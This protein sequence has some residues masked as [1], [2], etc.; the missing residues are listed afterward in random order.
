[1]IVNGII[2]IVI[3]Y[4][5][6]SI[7]SAYIVVRLTKGKDIREL[8]SGTVGSYNTYR[9]AGAKAGIAVAIADIGKGVATIA[10]AHYL[11]D[12]RMPFILAAGFA[13]IVGH[14]WMPLL[15]FRGGMGM[16]T[17]IGVMVTLLA[18]QQYWHQLFIFIGVIIV[19]LLITRNIALS[20]ATALLALPIILWVG[21]KSVPFTI[22]AAVIFLI[23]GL[24]F[25]PTA[26]AA[27]AKKKNKRS[28]FFSN[29]PR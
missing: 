11:M 27:W 6:G 23:I 9:H 17:A 24:K 4:L 1:M 19:P 12:V 15:K 10:V 16:A 20:A 2:A 29:S 21:T 7:P 28:F 13:A 26:R 14:M 22:L 5:L 3:G 18:I 8:G 25:L